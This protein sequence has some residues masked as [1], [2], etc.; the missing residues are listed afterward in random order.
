MSAPGAAAHFDRLAIRARQSLSTENLYELSGR[1]ERYIEV[2]AS[3]IEANVDRSILFRPPS[4]KENRRWRKF[5]SAS[6]RAAGRP[7]TR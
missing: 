3:F 7:A 4:G 6:G 1:L 2:V 5:R